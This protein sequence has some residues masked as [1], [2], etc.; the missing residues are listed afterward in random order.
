[1]R[2]AA[3]RVAA[4]VI[5]CSFA[6]P[7]ALAGGAA[8]PATLEAHVSFLASDA[9]AGRGT[10]SAGL[11]AAAAYI[12]SRFRAIGLE[13]VGDDGYYQTA[14]WTALHRSAGDLSI[15][16]GAGPEAFEVPEMHLA[17]PRAMSAI[18]LDRAP[19]ATL[20]FENPGEVAAGSLD[21]RIV[22]TRIPDMGA[23]PRAERQAFFGKWQAFGQA[24]Q[25]GG[26][27]VV[28][29]VEPD[30]GET[31]GV[32]GDVARRGFGLPGAELLRITGASAQRLLD[33]GDGA[34]LSIHLAPL[35]KRT[36]PVV[37]VVGLL[38]GSDP[39]LAPEHVIVSAH[40]DHVGTG[41]S[42]EDTIF[43]G[44]NDNA[45]GTAGVIEAAALLAAGER[46]RRSVLFI[47]YYGEER[48]LVGARHYADNPLLP[49]ADAV[50]NINLEQ[51]GRTD[52]DSGDV[53]KRIMPTGV[54]FSTALDAIEAAAAAKGVDVVA[55]EPQ[56]IQ[57]FRASDNAAL[58]AKGVPAHTLCT[59]FAF[60]EYHGVGDHWELLDYENMALI[61]E[62]VADGVRRLADASEA[63]SWIERAETRDFIAAREGVAPA[64][65]G[66]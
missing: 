56:T 5:A 42:G 10:P 39:D 28:L 6:A 9:L 12:A 25:A 35:E 66:D 64:P 59:A 13:P 14:D 48:G 11:D 17:A 55:L 20:D 15:V 40:Y 51:I 37:N 58:A 43:N 50:A 21:G 31:G 49:L 18:A 52:D 32:E 4:M 23:I 57:Y 46:P 7:A 36:T 2:I 26:A 1:M 27:T 33:A 30:A 47:C 65:A 44:A 19:V 38:E 53:A 16:L 22:L 8:S 3:C 29:S 62:V 34:T 60:P 61:V 24:V 54:G 45:S 63:P 41:G